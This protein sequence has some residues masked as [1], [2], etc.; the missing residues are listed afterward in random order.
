VFNLLLSELLGKRIAVSWLRDATLVVAGVPV[1]LIAILIAYLWMDLGYNFV[2]FLAG[3]QNIPESVMEA[4]EID[5]TGPLQKLRRITIPLLTPQIL[6]T[7]VLTMISAFQI[8]DL[9]QVMTEGGPNHTT[10]VIILDIFLNAFRHQ[11]MGWA[12]AVSIVFFAVVLV[13]SIVQTRL[14]RQDWEY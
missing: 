7:S 12:A 4:A 5:G 13:I 3:L 11:Q 14:L 10:R 9:V 6:L 8:Y 1:P 2:I